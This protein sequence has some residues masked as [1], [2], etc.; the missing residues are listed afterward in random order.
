MRYRPALTA[1]KATVVLAVLPALLLAGEAG[2]AVSEP[3]AA[4]SDDPGRRRGDVTLAPGPLPDVADTVTRSG[5]AKGLTVLTARQSGLRVHAFGAGASRA[6]DGTAVGVMPATGEESQEWLVRPSA[7]GELV[8]QSL[9]SS[10]DD[11]GALV[12]TTDPDDS[13]YLQHERPAGPDG[14][15]GQLWTFEDGSGPSDPGRGGPGF[16]VIAHRGGCLLDNGYGERLTVGQCEDPRAWWTAGQP[17][18]HAVRPALP[19]GS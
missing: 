3:A 11:A 12:L 7:G 16:R 4:P 2:H 9:L 17:V 6:A 1:A 14:D 13:V 15:P 18:G 8:L 10:S 5:P 19:S